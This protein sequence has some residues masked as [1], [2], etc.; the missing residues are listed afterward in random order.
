MVRENAGYETNRAELATMCRSAATFETIGVDGLVVGFARDGHLLDGELREVLH[1]APELPATFHRA[2]DSLNRPFDAIAALGDVPQIDRILTDGM[3]R[4]PGGADRAARSARLHAYS[5][6]AGSR[7][8]IVAGHAVD[9]EMLSEIA[10]TRCVGEVHVGRA[11]RTG[12]DPDGPVA[13]AR[14]RRLRDTLDR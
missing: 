1:A 4:R 5:D 8:I 10:V 11:A 6:L 3:E 12:N 9:E 2:F 13:A 14:V 7:L